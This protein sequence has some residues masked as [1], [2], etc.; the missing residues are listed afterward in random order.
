[1]VFKEETQLV[2]TSVHQGGT[3]SGTAQDMDEQQQSVD[4]DKGKAPSDEE[5]VRYGREHSKQS[6]A[7]SVDKPREDDDMEAYRCFI[8]EEPPPH[9]DV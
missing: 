4:K 2:D 8:M 1:M 6:A 3:T 9:N 5:K 7:S